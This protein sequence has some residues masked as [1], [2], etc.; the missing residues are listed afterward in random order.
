MPCPAGIPI[1]EIF[2]MY[3]KAILSG[4]MAGPKNFRKKYDALPADAKAGGCIRCG[5]CEEA[6]P[7]KLAIPDLL[8][9]L[10]TGEGTL[11]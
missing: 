5:R 6:C 7:Q 9:V 8:A 3:N 4:G 10:D 1:P 11:L 2:E